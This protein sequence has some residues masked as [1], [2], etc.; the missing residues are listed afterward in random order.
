MITLKELAASLAIYAACVA[1][2]AGVLAIAGQLPDA[3]YGS[4]S[5]PHQ[6]LPNVVAHLLLPAAFLGGAGV[7]IYAWVHWR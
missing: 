5:L 1:A 6:R 3:L 4:T 7:F 2:V